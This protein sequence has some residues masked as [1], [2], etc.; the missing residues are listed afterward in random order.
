MKNLF[1]LVVVVFS[2]SLNAY[3]DKFLGILNGNPYDPKSITNPYGT[4]S[5]YKPN[6]IN[7]PYGTYGSPYSNSSATNPY[8]TNIETRYYR[9]LVGDLD[10]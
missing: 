6:S 7:N 8:T 10:G 5:P 9:Q 2:L 4:G 3:A 1:S